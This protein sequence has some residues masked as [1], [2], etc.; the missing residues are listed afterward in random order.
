MFAD[1]SVLLPDPL[2][3]SV[4]QPLLWF[5][6]D[7]FKKLYHVTEFLVKT[8]CIFIDVDIVYPDVMI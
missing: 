8:P 7:L 6:S 2:N 3:K 5:R 1:F 4:H